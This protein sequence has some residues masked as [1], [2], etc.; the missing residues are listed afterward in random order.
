MDIHF[1]QLPTL[2]NCLLNMEYAYSYIY[3]EQ[4][5][6]TWT[7][8]SSTHVKQLKPSCL[9]SNDKIC[10]LLYPEQQTQTMQK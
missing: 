9:G 6:T 10:I 1:R 5:L 4:P 8:I 2:I 3:I 7:M